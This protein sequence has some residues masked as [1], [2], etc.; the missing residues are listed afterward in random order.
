MAQLRQ[1]YDKFQKLN[2]EI[3]VIGPEDAQTFE[4]YWTEHDLPFTGLPDPTHSVLKLYGQE[5]K[6]FKLG[7]MPAM[8]IVDAEG[9]VRYAHYGHSMRDIPDNDEV[10]DILTSL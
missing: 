10:L 2:V 1:D 5:V 9:I 7:R 3:L 6:L 4:K 8:V